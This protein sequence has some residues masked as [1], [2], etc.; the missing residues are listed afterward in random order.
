MADVDVDGAFRHVSAV[1][2]NLIDDPRVDG[3]V[4]TVRDD[5]ARKRFEQQLRH[6][7]FHD[8]LTGL[9]NRALFYDRTEH[10]LS[11]G[12]RGDAD[13]AVLFVD[14]DDFKP[15]N[16]RLGHAAGDQLLQLVA[17]RLVACVRSADTVA[18][19]GGDEFGIL[20]EGADRR[21]GRSRGACAGGARDALRPSER[22][23]AGLGQRRRR[24]QPRRRARRRGAAA[25]RGPRD[26]RGQARRQA[27]AR[28][29]R[30]GRAARR[31]RR[32][33]AA[34]HEQRG[35]AG[36]DHRPARGPRRADDGLPAR[37]RSAHGTRRRLRGAGALQP[38]A[39]ALARQVVRAGPPLRPRR[40]AR[41]ARAGGGAGGSRPS[42]G[43]P[44]DAEPEPVLARHARDRGGAARAPRG[45][46]DRGH[47]ERA[48]GRRPRDRR[49]DRFTARSRRGAGRRRHRRRLRRADARD[50]ARPR[51]DQARSRAH[52]RHRLRPGEGRAR[53]LLRA[54]RARH[55][56][57]RLRRGHRDR[58]RAGPARRARRGLRAGLPH[59]PPVAA[60]DR[61]RP[62][63]RR[64]L[65]RVV[66][67][68]VRR[69]PRRLGP[70]AADARASRSG[71]RARWRRWPR[72]C[73]PTRCWCPRPGAR[74]PGARLR[75]GEEAEALRAAGYGAKLVL[76]IGTRGHLVA[77]SRRERPW[78][79]FQLGRGRI[80]AHQ[81]EASGRP[82]S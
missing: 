67:R 41:G 20:L 69:G 61:R 5:D 52:H 14:L 40:R 7:A 26:V 42:R 73:A 45:L 62:G 43:H 68:R 18:R 10:A 29:P 76:P 1:A 65:A 74:R 19:L 66:P 22:G 24:G 9:A 30:P 81:L 17:K 27:P 50:A 36:G 46:R 75:A 8:E 54:L 13:V 31:G 12:A 37:A 82:L 33:A 58:R 77:Y 16:D 51:R 2:T 39:R 78:T 6:R 23:A 60:V 3:L 34:V 44:P 53:Q 59:R 4:L 15:V 21:R 56:R 11:R 48:R 80:L 70:R 25:R 57:D 49:R 63:A 79:R 32:F 47:R 64:G 38:H 55:R 28:D 72:C 35:A 71:A